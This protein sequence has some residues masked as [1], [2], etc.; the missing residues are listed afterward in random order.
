MKRLLTILLFS[1]LFGNCQ[2]EIFGI[3]KNN[4]IVTLQRQ[5]FQTGNSLGYGRLDCEPPASCNMGAQLYAA[6]NT[7]GNYTYFQTSVSGRTIHEMIAAL[8]GEVYSQFDPIYSQVFIAAIEGTNSIHNVVSGSDAYD[9]MMVYVNNILAHDSRTRVMVYMC[10]NCTPTYLS[11][12]ERVIYNNLLSATTQTY[13]FKVVD[14]T[15]IPELNNST[16]YLNATYYNADGIHLTPAGY[17][18]LAAKGI[19]VAQTF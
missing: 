5:L 17:N 15:G 19:T 14:I 11:E 12:T 2:R 7:H 16:A 1:P 3:D 10:I 9:S 6:L 13:R 8:P 18:L 4:V